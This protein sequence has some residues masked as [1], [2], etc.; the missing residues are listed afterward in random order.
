MTVRKTDIGWL[1]DTRPEGATG[2]RYRK[3]FETKREALEYEA[4]LKT[5]AAQTPGW[6]PERQDT[7]KLLD[8]IDIWYSQHGNQLA[9]GG[10]TYNRLKHMAV[11]MGNPYAAKMTGENFTEYRATRIQAGIS[12][13]NMNREKSYL[14]AMFNELARLEI[15]KGENP[16]RKVRAFKVPERELS[17][18]SLGQIGVLFDE[19]GK[20]RNPHVALISKVCLATGARWGEAEMLRR[21]QVRHGVIQF[22]KTKSKKVRAVPIEKHLEEELEAHFE[23]YGDPLGEQR[24]FAYAYSAF[25]D[26]LERT[27]IPLPDGQA[28]HVLRHTFASHFILNGGNIL[29]LQRILGHS[30]LAMTMRYAH[31]APDHLNEARSLNPLAIWRKSGQILDTVQ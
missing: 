31:L 29:V 21:P 6:K 15:W 8:L 30:S 22:A 17:F 24:F 7:R 25:I 2:K 23:T 26:T 14:Q 27:G 28:S 3:T 9:S 5:N 20:A 11:A 13:T 18:L 12:Q 16:L 1:T 19:L 10:D 4:W